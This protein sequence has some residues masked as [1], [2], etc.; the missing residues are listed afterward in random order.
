MCQ[1]CP[2]VSPSRGRRQEGWIPIFMGMT[3]GGMGIT[4]GGMGMTEGGMG[5][6]EG[7]M[8]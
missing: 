5:M 1:V 4:E 8:N 2:N 6:T 7:K 3:E